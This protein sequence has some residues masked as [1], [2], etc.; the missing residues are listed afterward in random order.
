MRYDWLELTSDVTI[1]WDAENATVKCSGKYRKCGTGVLNMKHA[2]SA[3][4]D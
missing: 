3:E 2:A 1:R 4:S